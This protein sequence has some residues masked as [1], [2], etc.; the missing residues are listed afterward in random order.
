MEVKLRRR[1]SAKNR[2]TGA[3]AARFPPWFCVMRNLG[4]SHLNKYYVDIHSYTCIYTSPFL[5][6]YIYILD[7]IYVHASLHVCIHLS[8]CVLHQC[9]TTQSNKGQGE[10]KYAAGRGEVGDKRFVRIVF[11]C[12]PLLQ[13]ICWMLLFLFPERIILHCVTLWITAWWWRFHAKP[14]SCDSSSCL[15][16]DLTQVFSWV[17]V[18]L[19]NL[20]LRFLEEDST[21]DRSLR[22]H[23]STV[24]R[25]AGLSASLCSLIWGDAG[26]PTS[27]IIH[28]VQSW[29]LPLGGEV[30]SLGKP[31]LFLSEPNTIMKKLHL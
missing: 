9:K 2:G 15:I 23:A 11:A 22:R 21:A 13:W 6:I 27:I 26:P 12:L 10:Q 20:W 17:D 4:S 7:Y 19:R 14:H 24:Q 16:G 30:V 3:S 5:H 28:H 31:V 1:K 25:N 29:R 18:A 8:V